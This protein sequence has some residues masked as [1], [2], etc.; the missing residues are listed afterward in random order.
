MSAWSG[1]PAARARSPIMA[2]G[3]P[4]GTVPIDTVLRA[5]FVPEQMVSVAVIAA[6]VALLAATWPAWKAARLRP[7]DAIHHV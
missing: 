6:I 7:I 2:A 4:V 1:M 3:S 5:A